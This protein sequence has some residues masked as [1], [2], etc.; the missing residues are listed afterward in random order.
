M[1]DREKKIGKKI[2]SLRELRGLT[3]EELAKK[4][5]FTKGYLSR[6]E[7][8]KKAPPVATI[9]TIA[10][11]L[12]VKISD[13]FGEDENKED[14]IISIVRKNERLVMARPGTLFGYHYES[15]VHEYRNK[16]IE[17]FL[18]TRP[19]DPS[20]K[21]ILFK[22]EG[23]ELLF[24]L[25]GSTEF[26]YGDQLYI[27]RAGDCACFDSSVKHY[28]KALGKKGVKMLVIVIPPGHKKGNPE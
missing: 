9:L 24:V 4:T 1:I 5:D 6:L 18:L 25:E 20:W 2:K 10:T 15:I 26:H 17:A 11:A 7:N 19:V 8:S 28:G 27:L 14:S 13:V 3:L 22:H 12:N 21:P 23:E 16:G